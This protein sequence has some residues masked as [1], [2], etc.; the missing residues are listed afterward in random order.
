MILAFLQSHL[1]PPTSGIRLGQD[2]TT[3]T[4]T[5]A[6]LHTRTLR[7]L[8]FVKDVNNQGIFKQLTE[9]MILQNSED[10]KLHNI[11]HIFQYIST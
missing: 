7:E 11:H 9:R 3:A 6:N 10:I 1:I 5:Q 4:A 2:S 8:I